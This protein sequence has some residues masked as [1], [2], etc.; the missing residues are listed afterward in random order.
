MPDRTIG[1]TAMGG[2]SKQVV[3]TIKELE[4]R[5][6]KAAWL[7]AGG[8]LDNLT[9]FAAAAAGTDRILLGT[10]INT[11]WSRHPV[12]AAQQVQVIGQLAPGRF[13]YGIGT[14]HARGM[15]TTFGADFTAPLGH[16]SEY[17]TLTRTLLGQGA[18]EFEGRFYRG[19]VKLAAPMPD[20]PVLAAALRPRAYEVCGE[21]A[22]GAISWVS[23][24]AYLR[25][26][27]LPALRRGAERGGRSVPPLVA[28]VPICVSED[29]EAVRTATREQLAIYPRAPFYQ[30]MFAE[31]GF[32]EAAETETWSDGMVE[33]V[34]FSGSEDKV[35]A[36]I[37]EL[38]D[39][40]ISEIIATV[41]TVGDDSAASRDRTLAL[42]SSQS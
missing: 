23:P 19:T 25:D 34:V 11:I 29:I 27:A 20:V 15:E 4:E 16:L 21:F 5:G 10:C 17:L 39:W 13:R 12:A 40:G 35:S 6:I 42:L 31:A 33:A 38:F 14:G 3:S 18:V 37:N 24:G 1:V 9:L 30:Q 8:G 2:D 28:H 32:P 7:T 26:V 22:D 41:V 36:R